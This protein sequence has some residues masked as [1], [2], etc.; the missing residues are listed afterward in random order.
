MTVRQSH[1][2]PTFNG[3]PCTWKDGLDVEGK[4]RFYG[5]QQICM[6]ITR[7]SSCGIHCQLRVI[8]M[9]T[10]TFGATTD[11][12][13]GIMIILS[14]QCMLSQFLCNPTNLQYTIECWHCLPSYRG[15]WLC[16]EIMA[17][18]T[19]KLDSMEHYTGLQFTKKTLPYWYRESNYNPEM[20]IRPS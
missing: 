12:K 11:D 6:F 8:M 16:G 19:P 15:W 20:V 14:F 7:G 2:H 13:V 17:H 10:T 9:P 4:P 18:R 5:V 3:N 1:D